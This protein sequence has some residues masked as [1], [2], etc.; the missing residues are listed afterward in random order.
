[1][2]R[3]IDKSKIDIRL[4]LGT[5]GTAADALS[6]RGHMKSFRP[7]VYV[8]ENYSVLRET[9]KERILDINASISAAR[10][11]RKEK[12][13]LIKYF[14]HFSKHDTFPDFTAAEVDPII[15]SRGTLVY[16]A[17]EYNRAESKYLDASFKGYPD[18]RPVLNLIYQ[19]RIDEASR[20]AE[21]ASR[22][23][24][25]GLVVFRNQRTAEGFEAMRSELP[26]LYPS[27][28]KLRRLRVFVRYGTSHFGLAESLES[29]GFRVS[30]VNDDRTGG[31]IIPMDEFC[32][33]LSSDR[34]ARLNDVERAEILFDFLYNS[35]RPECS[36]PLA[37]AVVQNA[38]LDALGGPDGFIRLLKSIPRNARNGFFSFFRSHEKAPKNFVDVLRF[39]I[40]TA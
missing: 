40:D 30:R 1:M 39:F 21:D 6:L 22:K 12:D 14:K 9:R 33:K 16:F 3:L 25:L 36:T 13:K 27:V 24:L 11:S 32:R 34:N 23:F 8:M 38:K 26:A 29:L 4:S 31:I 37:E 20:L 2:S 15:D 17:E 7:H 10:E 35:G 28:E 18:A 19:N 5:H